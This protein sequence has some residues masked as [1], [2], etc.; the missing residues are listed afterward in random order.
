[1]REGRALLECAQAGP[2][3]VFV[4]YSYESTLL[5]DAGEFEGAVDAVRPGIEMMHRHGMHRSHQSWP[6]AVQA[7]ALITL[8][9]W[10]EA[11]SL[12]ETALARGPVGITRR[13]LLLQRAELQLGRGEMATASDTLVQARRAAEGD[14]RSLASCSS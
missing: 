3:L 5:V 7:S 2:D 8:G 11:A 14:T 12:V 6:E 9:R 10:T 1:L 13:M 4:T